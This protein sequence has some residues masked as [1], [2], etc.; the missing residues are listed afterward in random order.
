VHI[1]PLLCSSCLYIWNGCFCQVCFRIGSVGAITVFSSILRSSIVV[2]VFSIV[3]FCRDLTM[4][5]PTPI[6]LLCA[7]LLCL[8]ME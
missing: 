3:F 4:R 5:F 1:V 8:S 2:A 7:L 6:P